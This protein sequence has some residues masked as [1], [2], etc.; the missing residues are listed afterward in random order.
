MLCGMRT[1][2]GKVMDT[3][4]SVCSLRV[5]STLESVKSGITL[6]WEGGEETG[7]EGGREGGRKGE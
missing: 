6:R 2:N 3:S 7:G 5:F 1:A 4:S